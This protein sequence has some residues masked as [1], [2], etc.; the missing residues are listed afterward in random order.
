MT[1]YCFVFLTI[2]QFNTQSPSPVPM[3]WASAW[4]RYGHNIFQLAWIA[5]DICLVGLTPKGRWPAPR[6]RQ[7]KL[8]HIR[9]R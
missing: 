7:Y 3:T 4:L 2:N 6:A 1:I 9:P 8:P 5:F